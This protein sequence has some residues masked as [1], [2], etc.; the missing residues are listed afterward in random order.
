MLKADINVSDQPAS[1]LSGDVKDTQG[2]STEQVVQ[3]DQVN[4]IC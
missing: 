3:V 4:M 1:A 2:L